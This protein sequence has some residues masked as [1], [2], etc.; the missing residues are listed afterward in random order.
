[1]RNGV[2]IA[3]FENVHVHAFVAELLAIGK[4]TGS[5]NAGPLERVTVPAL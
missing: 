4:G 1:M 5:A 3:A 2:R